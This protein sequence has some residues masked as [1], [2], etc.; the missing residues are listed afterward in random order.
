MTEQPV[1]VFKEGTALTPTWIELGNFARAQGVQERVRVRVP[2]LARIGLLSTLRYGR[3]G[4]DA[5][6]G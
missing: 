5:K 3:F 6:K 1:L 4:A 2:K